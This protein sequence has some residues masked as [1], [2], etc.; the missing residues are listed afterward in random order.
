[1]K[2]TFALF[3]KLDGIG[4]S[5]RS[6][7]W[8]DQRVWFDG[9]G[10]LGV[11]PFVQPDELASFQWP[12]QPVL[13]PKHMGLFLPS[14]WPNRST[15]NL[16]LTQKHM[17]LFLPSFWPNLS[18]CSPSIWAS[19]QLAR[20]VHVECIYSAYGVHDIQLWDWLQ[21]GLESWTCD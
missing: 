13:D 9:M 20:L 1:M 4:W 7:R 6:D 15:F 10:H 14:F 8:S 2:V 3:L 12:G 11:E 16:C 19:S 5:N 21:W 18:T 17:G